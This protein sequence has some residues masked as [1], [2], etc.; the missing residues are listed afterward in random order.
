[1]DALFGTWILK[2]NINFELFLQYYGYGWM[3]RKVALAS[4]IELDIQSGGSRRISKT[5]KSNFFNANEDCV[6]DDQFHMNKNGIKKKNSFNKNVL[7]TIAE[8]TMGSW[9][10][11][12]YVSG[13]ELHVERTWKER[14]GTHHSCKQIFIKK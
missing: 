13:T 2:K 11:R 6:F 3:Q 9:I 14:N 4:S 10:E 8:G 1:M 12:A 7:T 5:I